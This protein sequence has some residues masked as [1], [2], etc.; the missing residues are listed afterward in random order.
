MEAPQDKII[1]AGAGLAG[2]LMAIYLAKQG[3]DVE[4]YEK[5]PDM[6]VE[7]IGGG[8]SINLALSPR[9]MRPLEEVG[10][11]D[12]VL[13][14]SIPMKGRMIHGQDGSTKFQPYGKFDHEY[15]NSVSRSELNKMLMD[16]AESTGRVKINF[17]EP[18]AGIDPS[19]GDF[20]LKE[21]RRIR[22]QT[23]IGADGAGSAVRYTMQTLG[24]FNY[25][26]SFLEHGYKEL[27]IPPDEKGQHVIDKNSL[28][29]W[30]R[31]S[32]MLIALPNPDGSFTATLFLKF[33]GEKS[34][35]SLKTPKLIEEFFEEYFP[36][37]VEIMPTYVDDFMSNPV[38]LLGTIRTEPWHFSDISLLI[39]DA[40]HAIVPFYGQ[41]MNAAFE[42][43]RILNKMISEH[44]G[45]W[46]EIFPRFSRSR[47]P[48]ADAIADLA[49]ENF[50]EMRDSV[51]DDAFLF[52]KQIE[53][54]LYEKYPREIITKYSMVTFSHIPYAE[55]KSKGELLMEVIY[56]RSEGIDTLEDFDYERARD[57]ILELYRTESHRWAG[58]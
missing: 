24:R 13:K 47:K 25:S 56:R 54:K 43:C 16:A 3:Y 11:L 23:I 17:N 21:G 33:E 4:V 31:K 20:L 5:R 36:D 14:I 37:A 30:P 19:T 7:N 34:F 8:K 46:A 51:A 42:D 55:A 35:A 15:I 27:V 28:H 6:R 48:N 18:C 9:G 10:V 40:A 38:G 29:I 49:L 41:G 58:D 53:L 52:R 57:E 2:S 12:D 26:Q 39:G 1:L 32:F 44:K 45:N 22:G 50:I